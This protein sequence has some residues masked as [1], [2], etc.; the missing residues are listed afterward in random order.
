M[1]AGVG[2]AIQQAG[3]GHMTRVGGQ[4]I[5]AAL[6]NFFVGT[7]A[8]VILTA[9]ITGF[10]PPN[11][12]SAPPEDW[13]GGLIGAAIAA[14]LSKLVSLFGVLPVILGLV[15][16]QTTGGLLIDLFEPSSGHTVS[17]QT[18]VSVALTISAVTGSPAS[19]GRAPPPG[20]G[21]WSA[22]PATDRQAALACASTM[23]WRELAPGDRQLVHLVGPVGEAQRAQ[24]RV[25]RAPAGSRRRRRR[26]RAPGSRG[27]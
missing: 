15:A 21:G 18:V 27:R 17:A 23:Y 12:W 20:S 24:V 1:I 22:C 5:A 26:R 6:V 2:V 19:P 14:T 8:L 10:Q 25:H 7:T 9:I 11:G 3:L 13:V 16:G 4:P